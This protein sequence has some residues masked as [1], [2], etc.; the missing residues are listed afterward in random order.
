MS[1]PH[2]YHNMSYKEVAAIYNDIN[3]IPP[4][5]SVELGE[6]VRN[7][8]GE[9]AKMLDIGA[10]AGRISVPIAAVTDMTALDLEH[11]MLKVSRQL[12]NERGVTMRHV[13]GDV[14]NLPFPDNAFDAVITTNV[15]HQVPAWRDAIREA[16]RVMR[17][18]APMLFGR[19]GLDENTNAYKMRSQLREFT[20]SVMPDMRP[21]DAAGPALMQFLG[22]IGGR[23]AGG[24]KACAWTED[25]SARDILERM[26]SRRH[27]ETWTLDD[28]TLDAVMG[29]MRPWVEENIDDP[30]AEEKTEWSLDL[31]TV[32]GLA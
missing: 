16:A 1:E 11:E 26:E 25:C 2:P 18:G 29:R 17:P 23:P 12:A 32:T 10:G 6:Y 27:N 31:F 4:D 5:A 19:S 28:A 22:E 24:G 21:T 20:A 30:D 3:F 7:I 8:V 9:G 13:T 15:F 14:L